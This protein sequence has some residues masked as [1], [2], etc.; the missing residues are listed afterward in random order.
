MI[1]SCHPAPTRSPGY[2][3]STS[4]RA[5]AAPSLTRQR[6]PRGLRSR[7]MSPS[8]EATRGAHGPGPR[9]L[10]RS[11]PQPFASLPHPAP[12]ARGFPLSDSSWFPV[13]LGAPPCAFCRRACRLQASPSFCTRC[14]VGVERAGL[15]VAVPATGGGGITLDTD[16]VPTV[17]RPA[18]SS[19]RRMKLGTTSTSRSLFGRR[20]RGVGYPLCLDPPVGR[21]GGASARSRHSNGKAVLPTSLRSLGAF[22]RR[23]AP[24]TYLGRV[25]E[26]RKAAGSF[27]S[28]S[29]TL[30]D[31]ISPLCLLGPAF[32]VLHWACQTGTGGYCPRE[33]TFVA[34]MVTSSG[35]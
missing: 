20:A 10:R 12:C 24:R 28:G 19:C 22:V 35:T 25:F 8:L 34:E 9:A 5:V 33:S 31:D 13:A 7:R 17:V 21:R 27:A 2:V 15:D 16:L 6:P 26:S 18:A 4:E 11:L 3:A 30:I 29:Q 1:P 14:L 32:L 23:D